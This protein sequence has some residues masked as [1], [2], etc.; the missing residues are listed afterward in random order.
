MK[1]LF[2]SIAV[3]IALLAAAPVGISS[4]YSLVPAS[5]CSGNAAQS[6]VCEGR[7]NKTN[8]LIGANGLLSKI[9]NIVAVIA[10]VAA[11]I[12]I[13]LA[14]LRLVQSGGSSED[15]AGARRSIIY[16][17]VGLVVI[18]LARALIGLALNAI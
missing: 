14:G 11:V 17:I 13:I 9:A 7:N 10:G 12:I 4:A 5:D 2:A 16:A 18:V 3:A 8:P 15:V 1:K 6:A